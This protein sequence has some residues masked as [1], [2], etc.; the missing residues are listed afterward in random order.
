MLS[1]GCPERLTRGLRR[2]VI[3]P[4][5]TYH[6]A[7]GSRRLPHSS[8]GLAANLRPSPKPD[9]QLASDITPGLRRMFYA[10]ASPVTQP[11]TYVGC[12]IL[13]LSWRPARNFGLLSHPP[14]CAGDGRYPAS[15]RFWVLR[16]N[17]WPSSGLRRSWN[18]SVQPIIESRLI[19]ISSS[20][21][22]RPPRL[23]A[24][25]GLR[26]FRLSQFV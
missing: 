24:F 7:S 23:P 14:A 2:Y 22:S 12:L 18:P 15:A 19:G 6:A 16:F 9:L 4:G 1:F 10:S 8:P 26:F 13:R 11:P 17:R 5:P 25:A 3:H 21:F 20:C